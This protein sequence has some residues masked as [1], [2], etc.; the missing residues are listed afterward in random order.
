MP[1]YFVLIAGF[2]IGGILI[3]SI[4]LIAS[5]I[6][7]GIIMSYRVYRRKR[8]S[9]KLKVI[10]I[11]DHDDHYVR[12]FLDYYHADIAKYFPAFDF[13]IEEEYLVALILSEMETVG[14]LI[15]EIKNPETLRICVDYMVP[16][17]RRSQLAQTFYQCELLCVDFLGYRH[18]YIEPQSKE[19]NQYLQKIGFRLVDGK[20]FVISCH[21]KQQTT[22]V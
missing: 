13:A 1:L 14:L 11:T 16:K 4:V 5:A 7:T 2:L 18:L 17:Y 3:R 21:S 15:A 20:Y 6:L 22:M 19:H 12:H 10:F 8:D 9:R